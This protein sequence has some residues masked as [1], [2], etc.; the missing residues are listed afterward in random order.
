MDKKE[1]KEK[2]EKN[3]KKEK[4]V[5]DPY[6]QYKDFRWE[7]PHIFRNGPVDDYSRKCRDC[8]CCIIFIIFIAAC[9]VVGY[10]GFSKGNPKAL[11]Y[12]YDVEGNA[13][14]H[15]EGFEDYPY[16]Y[17]YSILSGASSLNSE[18]ISNG[19]CVKECPEEKKDGTDKTLLCRKTKTIKSCLVQDKY[20]YE[21]KQIL[22]RI[23]FPKSD[24]ELGFNPA[25][26]KKIKIYDPKLGETFEKIININDDIHTDLAGKE[27]YAASAITDEN[28]P[29]K[30]GQLINISFFS[31]KFAS[32]ISDLYATR[33]AIIASL[34]WSF[35]IAIL[36][37]I[38]L[39]CFAGFIIYTIIVLVQVGLI[40]LAIFF[41]LTVND[42]KEQDDKTYQTT[43]NV[44]FY[45]FIILAV[46]W[47]LFIIVMCNKIRLAIT[48]ARITSKYIKGTFCLIFVPLFFFIIY[49]IWIAYWIVLLIFLYS[50]GDFDQ[51][52]SR[53]IA[54]FKMDVKIHLCFWFHVFTLLY[55]TA[56]I[57]AYSHFVYASSACIW[58]FTS[59][60][61]TEPFPIAKSF[62]RGLIYHFGSLAFGALIVGTIQFIML[63]FEF[64]KRNVEA[65]VSKRV[66][67][68]FKCLISC[69]QCCLACVAKCMEFINKHAYIQIALKGDSFCTAAWEGYG[70]IIRNIRRF[71]S[72]TVIGAIFSFIGTIF[73][74][75]ASAIV[76]YFVITKA[77]YFSSQLGSVILPVIVFALIGFIIG[78]ATLSIF[79][80]SGD[81]LIHSFLLDEEINN[82][83]PKAFPELQKFMNEER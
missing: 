71:S 29:Q 38:F 44:F 40:I 31:N 63:F 42:V 81:A 18:T 32:W 74:T 37:L 58:Y 14:G 23:C 65:T 36:F 68:C 10:V 2:N 67:K 28:D 70:L 46:I 75:I 49:I 21:S 69:V 66:G 9:V 73:V 41:K 45:V 52:R 16:L 35:V 13:C 39:R 56:V 30:A 1:K 83:Q 22:K 57:N 5:N 61:G 79:S 47:F 53:V 27:Y 7:Y 11:L 51:E 78:R 82:G 77:E 4:N 8:V 15:T 54:S 64:L 24:D 50:S 33:Y 43:M 60:K 34:G 48:M 12:V 72:M 80:V 25:T 55:I 6:K 19:F 3:E 62:K 59:E 76:G 26:Q 20:Y 17:F